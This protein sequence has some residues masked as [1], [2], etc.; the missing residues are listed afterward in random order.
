[1]QIL[2]ANSIMFKERHSHQQPVVENA[3]NSNVYV[4]SADSLMTSIR[5][6]LYILEGD[7]S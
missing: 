4:A 7:Y 3:A 2:Q 6:Y 1:M 5:R